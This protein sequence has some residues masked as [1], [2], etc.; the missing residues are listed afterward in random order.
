[1]GLALATGLSYAWTGPTANPPNNNAPAPISVS[2]VSQYKAGALGIGGLFHAY[3]NAIVDGN[4]GIG[5]DAPKNRLHIKGTNWPALFVDS[6]DARGGFIGYGNNSKTG[7]ATGMEEDGTWRI[8]SYSGSGDWRDAWTNG[9]AGKEGTN[10]IVAKKD[11]KVGLG[12]VDPQAVLHIKAGNGNDDPWALRIEQG[13]QPLKGK[14]LTAVDDSGNAEWVSA[15]VSKTSG[16]TV[17]ENAGTVSCGAKGV[18]NT[19]SLGRNH[20]CYMQAVDF[21]FEGSGDT[22]R[23]VYP[24]DNP[25]ASGKRNWNVGITCYNDSGSIT[26]VCVNF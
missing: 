4:V 9:W 10:V 21:G 16:L 2:S 5:T 22:W 17:K 20:F 13:V 11:G 3:T 1:M 25:D 19:I 7:W 15:S 26:A 24:T 6:S 8:E 18:T 23:G 12:T 14:V